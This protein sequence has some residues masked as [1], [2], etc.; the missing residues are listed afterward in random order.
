MCTVTYIPQSD[1]F[2]LTSNRDEKVNRP[3]TLPDMYP[4]HGQQLIYPKDQRA[5][6]T[7]IA[8][9]LD[10]TFAC[11]L[12]GAFNA[13]KKQPHH[14]KSRGKVLLESF[15]YADVKDFAQMSDFSAVEPFTLLMFRADGLYE[16]RWDGQYKFL[17]KI[18]KNQ[19]TIWSSSTLYSKDTRDQRQHVFYSWLR[20]QGHPAPHHLFDFHVSRHTT[21]DQN[22]FVMKR[23][24]GL[25]TVSITQIHFKQDHFRMLYQDLTTER[26]VKVID[27]SLIQSTDS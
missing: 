14:T 6:G 5:G 13:H 22:D 11:L 7:W 12:N 17:K 27:S 18:N 19:P 9:S 16:C 25:Q 1:G 10:H 20:H 4:H 21:D 8:A 2:I 23:E 26:S 15:A 24:G 3:T